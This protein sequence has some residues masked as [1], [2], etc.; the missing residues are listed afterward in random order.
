MEPEGVLLYIIFNP[1]STQTK[2]HL[3]YLQNRYL[4]CCWNP[5][6]NMH[7]DPTKFCT[8]TTTTV[9]TSVLILL[10][11]SMCSLVKFVPLWWSGSVH[12][13][14]PHA[15][16]RAREFSGSIGGPQHPHITNRSSKSHGI[17]LQSLGSCWRKALQPALRPH[18]WGFAVGRIPSHL[19]F[20]DLPVQCGGYT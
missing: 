10:L 19:G 7:F 18:V 5:N 14:Q 1:R 13:H 8:R 11:M 12:R 17:L 15:H 4:I 2:L 9:P 3:H 6:A 20:V 16:T